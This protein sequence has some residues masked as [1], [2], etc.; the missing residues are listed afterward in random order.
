MSIYEQVEL[1]FEKGGF[2]QPLEA[3]LEIFALKRKSRGPRRTAKPSLKG[4]DLS[5]SLLPDMVWGIEHAWPSDDESQKEKLSTNG[6]ENVVHGRYRKLLSSGRNDEFSIP[7][8]ETIALLASKVLY[9]DLQVLFITS[10]KKSAARKRSILDWIFA[11]SYT[12]GSSRK[13]KPGETPMHKIPFTCQFCCVVEEI[14]YELLCEVCNDLVD[15]L[16]E[17]QATAKD[18]Q[19]IVNKETF[20]YGHQDYSRTLRSQFASHHPGPG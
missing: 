5:Q 13:R 10:G 19:P 6:S 20:D 8:V 11:T 3:L 18:A 2:T 14:N 15:T 4:V 12:G 9:A 7:T 16:R 1:P 17:S